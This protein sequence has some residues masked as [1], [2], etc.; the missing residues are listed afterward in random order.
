MPMAIWTCTAMSERQSRDQEQAQQ[1]RRLRGGRAGAE[2]VADPERQERAGVNPGQ[3]RHR[4]ED[5][6]VQPRPVVRDPVEPPER[7]WR[8]HRLATAGITK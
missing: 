2:P 7:P 4:Q 8:R 3:Q 6:E 1:R 5:A